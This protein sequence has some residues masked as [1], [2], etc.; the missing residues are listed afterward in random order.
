MAFMTWATRDSN[1]SSAALRAAS[2]SPPAESPELLFVSPLLCTL[3]WS[4]VSI[5]EVSPASSNEAWLWLTWLPDWSDLDVT[6]SFP[7]SLWGRNVPIIL[8]LSSCGCYTPPYLEDSLMGSLLSSDALRDVGMEGG[9]VD[10][11]F[12]ETVTVCR[13]GVFSS[14]F[15]NFLFFSSFF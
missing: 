8:I 14:T 10:P 12:E 7:P 15:S 2:R 5:K 1:Y 11:V 6:L 9:S 4:D 13:L 3:S